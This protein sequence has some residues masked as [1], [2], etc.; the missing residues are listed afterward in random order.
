MLIASG[1][2]RILVLFVG[3]LIHFGNL[4]SSNYE[5][6]IIL[7]LVDILIYISLNSN[8]P[9]YQETQV[10]YQNKLYQKKLQAISARHGEI[11]KYQLK[12]QLANSSNTFH[13]IGD[14]LEVQWLCDELN[15][16]AGL[17]I[18]HDASSV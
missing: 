13:I 7:E 14:R 18:H 9:A 12:F 8:H 17:E 6:A 15:E 2:W 1:L 11:P 16:W 3:A 4:S 10:F 5:Y